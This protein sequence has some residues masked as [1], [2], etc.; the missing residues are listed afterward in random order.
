MP[1]KDLETYENQY[2]ALEWKYLSTYANTLTSV[3]TA[4]ESV[5][6]KIDSEITENFIII[7]ADCLHNVTSSDEPLLMQKI[8]EECIPRF[9]QTNIKVVE[10]TSI[11][12]LL[13]VVQLWFRKLIDIF[14][15]LRQNIEK[16]RYFNDNVRS[17]NQVSPA[18]WRDIMQ[19][20]NTVY[21]CHLSGI[22]VSIMGIFSLIHIIGRHYINYFRKFKNLQK[23]WRG[24]LNRRNCVKCVTYKITLMSLNVCYSIK[25]SIKIQ[26]LPKA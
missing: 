6:A 11:R 2:N 19:L 8:Q 10:I 13:F 4:Y 9:G 24:Q 20:V 16:L 22:R 26:I 1:V 21:D 15:K 12:T 25:L 18:I 5:V 23:K 17:R 7:M 3:K 14:N